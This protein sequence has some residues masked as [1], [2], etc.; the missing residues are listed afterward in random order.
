MCSGL[1]SGILTPLGSYLYSGQTSFKFR[2]GDDLNDC[3]QENKLVRCIYN[4]SPQ[5]FIAEEKSMQVPLPT[6][7]VDKTIRSTVSDIIL[8][9]FYLIILLIFDNCHDMSKAC[10]Y[11]ARDTCEDLLSLVKTSPVQ[12]CFI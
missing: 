7:Y 2:D 11:N 6:S 4:I 12:E 10:I 8:L 9:Y 3:A 1:V 5:D